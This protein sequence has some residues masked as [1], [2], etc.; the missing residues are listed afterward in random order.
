MGKKYMRINK[1]AIIAAAIMLALPVAAN[2]SAPINTEGAGI[3]NQLNRQQ[4]KDFETN[5][6][7]DAKIDKEDDCCK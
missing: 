7:I 2:A 3:Y 5:K 4:I 1:L 6:Q